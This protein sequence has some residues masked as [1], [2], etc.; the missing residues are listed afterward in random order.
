MA[1]Q[2]RSSSLTASTPSWAISAFI[3]LGGAIALYGEELATSAVPTR[4]VVWGSL[5]LAAYAAA[6]LC[7]LGAAQVS[8]LGL[9][10]WSLGPWILLWYGLTFGLTTVTWSRPQPLPVGEI[11]VSS[12]LRALWLVAVAV[13]FWTIGYFVGPT[14]L[15]RR[16]A[17]RG[18]ALLAD[19]RTGIVRSTATPWFIYAVGTAARVASAV[20]TGRFGY[21]GNAA[22]AVSTATGYQQILGEL[23]FFCPLAVA[24]AAL[25]VYKERLPSARITLCVLFVAEIVSGAASGYKGTFITAVLAVVVPMSAARYRLPKG[26]LIGAALIFLVVALPFN[27]AYRNTVRGASTT[28]ST[29]QAIDTGPAILRQ[30]VTSQNLFAGLGNATT[31]LLQ[32][33]QEIDGPAIIVQRTPGQIAFTSSFQLVEGPLV[34]MIP[35]AIWPGKPI[36]AIGYQFS[37]Q[38]YETPAAV[39]TSSAI[40]PIGDLYR[41][42]GWI[43][44][45]AGMFIFGGVVRLLDDVL[46]I[47][48]NPH[49]IFLVL[50][51]FPN[52]VMGE[53]D[54]VTLI[55][56]MP[57][58]VLTWLLAIS[59]TFR[60]RRSM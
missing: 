29:S 30:A 44:V 5:A 27:Q 20:T 28:L 38:Y 59:L 40:S 10:K 24:A 14:H 18:M 60:A 4:S 43:P 21:V 42:G 11:A 58:T 7:L 41:H 3:L 34:D 49:A 36:L 23:S 1:T 6:L 16:H 31:Y 8:G 48:E 13:T 47:R 26:L 32:R 2:L 56:S 46:D 50:L 35:R 37:Q 9:A 45:I 17:S 12:V 33:E 25:Q 19:R 57:A 54:Y 39:Y 15:L 53:S 22:S 52:L 51:L 55:A